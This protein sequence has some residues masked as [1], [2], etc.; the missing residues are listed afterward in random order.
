M[1]KKKSRGKRSKRMEQP[2]KTGRIV[3]ELIVSYWME[4]ETVQ[5]YLANSTNLTGVLAKEI[6]QS[7]AADVPAELGHAQQLAAR[8]HVLGGKVPGSAGFRAGQKKLQPPKD[9]TDVTAVI[10]GVIDA[11]QGAIEQYQK[12]IELCEGADYA[13][14]ELAIR[15]L[16]DEQEHRREFVGFLSE[17]DK[18]AAAKLG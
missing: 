7:L 10:L 16:A 2:A 13:T 15:I 17:Y 11:E 6:K 8:I 5:N 12:I 4:L 1:A 18:K 3:E 14:Q 9:D